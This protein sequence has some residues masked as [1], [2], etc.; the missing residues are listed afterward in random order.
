MDGFPYIPSPVGQLVHESDAFIKMLMGPYGS[1]KSCCMA[2]EVLIYA[3]CQEPAPPNHLGQRIRYSK[4]GVIRGSYPQ[5]QSATRDSLMQVLPDSCGRINESGSPIKGFYF[6]PLED[7][8]FVHLDLVLCAVEKKSDLEKFKSMNWSFCWINEADAICPEAIAF[9]AG[10]IGRYPGESLGG[11]SWAGMLMDFNRP[12]SGHYLLELMKKKELTVYDSLGNS[13]AIPIDVFVQPPAAFK[14][15]R[16]DGSIYYEVNSEAENLNNLKGGTAFY[17]N[18]IGLLLSTGSYD[19]IDVTFCL[20]DAQIKEGRPVFESFEQEVHVAPYPIEPTP[21][22]QLV[23]GYDTSG[24]HPGTTFLQFLNKRWCVLDELLG[25]GVGFQEFVF[26]HMIPL[27]LRRYA[28]CER[29]VACDYADARLDYTGLSPTAHLQ[30]AGL[31]TWKPDTNNPKIRH[32]AVN[33][34]LNR[35]NGGL[36]ISSNCEITIG[37]LAGGYHYRKLGRSGSGLETKYNLTPEKNLFSHI[38]D[39]L[40]YAAMFITQ[41]SQHSMMPK[42]DTGLIAGY[43]RNYQTMKGMRLM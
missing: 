1:G 41:E 40:Q 9:F 43:Q 14:R 8:T 6:M 18:Q 13:K 36:L 31:E 29:I 26:N 33:T 24:I 27:I 22:V 30:M 34:L 21:H 4:V 2:M 42:V 39:S 38:A 12:A 35:R 19:E 5:L 17:E 10:R 25:V 37:A 3:A 15:K 7:G 11:V 16:A 23:I 20:L 28:F 32:G